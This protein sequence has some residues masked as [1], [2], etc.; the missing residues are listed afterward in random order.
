MARFF[1]RLRETAMSWLDGLSDRDRRLL[2][3]LSIGF[4]GLMLVFGLIFSVARVT[5]KRSEL[6]RNKEQLAQIKDLESQYLEARSKVEQAKRRVKLN[7]V[8]LFTFIQGITSRLGLSVNDLTEQSRPLP[9]SDIVEVSVRLNLT[10]LS[11]DK[12]T[13]LIEELEQ[14]DDEE[15]VKVTKLKINKSYSEPEL[16]DVQ[17][18]VSTWKST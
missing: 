18:T 12:V 16:L 17:M 3:I 5:S 8:S 13:A 4:L 7:D 10:K 9:K 6:N 1:E 11:I 2:G 14:E 15:L